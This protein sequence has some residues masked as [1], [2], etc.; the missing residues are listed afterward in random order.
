MITKPASVTLRG[1][2]MPGDDE[3]SP[4]QEAI[5]KTADGKPLLLQRRELAPLSYDDGGVYFR[6]LNTEI[7]LWLLTAAG[8]G[9]VGNLAYDTLKRLIRDARKL[10]LKWM[11][12]T[13]QEEQ[14]WKKRIRQ[15][16]Q[17]GIAD[18]LYPEWSPRVSPDFDLR[19]DLVELAYDVLARYRNL[20]H[21][22]PAH[23]ISAIDVYRTKSSTWAVVIRE[24]RA[25]Q[26]TMV[27]IDLSEDMRKGDYEAV[28]E[29]GGFPVSIWL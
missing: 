23:L 22:N 29:V 28:K 24:L 10:H 21:S 4:A 25:W 1:Y 3:A 16:E 12:K 27:E 8:S 11:G 18:E 15:A 2:Q 19:E 17:E 7:V 14:E 6:A 13:R 5:K 26:R 9:I 20:E